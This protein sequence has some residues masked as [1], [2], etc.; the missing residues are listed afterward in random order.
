[1]LAET[2]KG[3]IF[4]TRS[5]LV[6]CSDLVPNVPLA[7]PMDAQC[8]SQGLKMCELA[9]L[10]AGTEKCLEEV[11]AWMR[12]ETDS[13]WHLVPE[14]IRLDHDKPPTAAEMASDGTM[15]VIGG[16][17]PNCET[18]Q[19]EGATQQQICEYLDALAGWQTLRILQRSAGEVNQ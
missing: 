10:N 1:M 2:D 7:I 16:S 9:L 8:I 6:A 4:D 11:T 13:N 19:I 17:L 15:A 14:D 18:M 5:F 12:E 3:Q